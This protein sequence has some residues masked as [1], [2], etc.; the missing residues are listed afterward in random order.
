[1]EAAVI[2]VGHRPVPPA[3]ALCPMFV[4]QPYVRG[5]V[6]AFV[7]LPDTEA[8][9]SLMLSQVPDYSELVV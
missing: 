4:N 3:R 6:L 7:A 9:K 5:L 2:L 1:M 8:F